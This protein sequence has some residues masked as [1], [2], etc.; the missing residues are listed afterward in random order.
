MVTGK[1]RKERK[2]YSVL[3]FLLAYVLTTKLNLEPPSSV[4]TTIK[5]YTTD[6]RSFLLL[7]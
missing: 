3:A 2:N 5:H 7:C 6:L 1:N 4:N